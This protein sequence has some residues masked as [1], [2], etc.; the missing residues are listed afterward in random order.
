MYFGT[1]ATKMS[2]LTGLKEVLHG[3]AANLGP[4]EA[5]QRD[6]KAGRA[7]AAL[8]WLKKPRPVGNEPDTERTLPRGSHSSDDSHSTT[9]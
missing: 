1:V 7:G 5:G 8:G 6:R 4:R 9:T 3:K 2:P